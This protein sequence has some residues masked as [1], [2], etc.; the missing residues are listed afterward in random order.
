M[1][2]DKEQSVSLNCDLIPKWKVVFGDLKCSMKF[3]EVQ[4]D[5]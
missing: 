1:D 2:R 4:R 5:Q 3:G